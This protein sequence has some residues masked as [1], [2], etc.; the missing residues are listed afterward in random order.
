MKRQ[1]ATCCCTWLPHVLPHLVAPPPRLRGLATLGTE[2]ARAGSKRHPWPAL[3]CDMCCFEVP[4]LG[5]SL[6]AMCCAQER[7]MFVI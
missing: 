7:R 5:F 2:H 1:D 4:V 6:C 3:C